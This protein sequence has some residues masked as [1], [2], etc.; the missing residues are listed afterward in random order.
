MKLWTI[1]LFFLPSILGDSVFDELESND[2]IPISTRS[3]EEL[4]KCSGNS[5]CGFL[6]ANNK[7]LTSV[8][9]CECGAGSTCP[10]EWDQFDGQSISQATSDQYKFCGQAPKLEECRSESQIAYTS[11]QKYKGDAKVLIRDEIHC[12]CP[13][14]SSY[15]DVKFNFKDEGIFEIVEIDYYCLPLVECN[16]T[17]TCKDITEKPGEYV[18]NPKCICPGSMVC[19]STTDRFATTERMGN[20]ILHKIQ[21]QPP[22]G[23][24]KYEDLYRL[25]QNLPESSNLEAEKRKVKQIIR[26]QQELSPEKS[27][28]KN[29]SSKAQKTS[30]NQE[31]P[32]RWGPALG[33]FG[34]WK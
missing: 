19:S 28:Q 18:V 24:G 32:V 1:L 7:G 9:Y 6:Q 23:R 33:M 31:K 4:P 8:Q 10:L 12:V 27:R 21:C 5:I 2:L 15:Q 14:G 3:R 16:V 30:K 11:Y 17:D 13:F 34:G 25:L 29:R 22:K 26:M 20:M